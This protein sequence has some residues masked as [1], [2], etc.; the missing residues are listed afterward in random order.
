MPMLVT[1]GEIKETHWLIPGN[2]SGL[3]VILISW[4]PLT[5]SFHS[6][7][8]SLIFAALGLELRAFTLSHSTSPTFVKSFSRYDLV[9]YLPR[10]ASNLNPPVLCLLSS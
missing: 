1:S 3:L 6:F 10:S 9:N 7:I 8:H 5:T 4:V 2:F